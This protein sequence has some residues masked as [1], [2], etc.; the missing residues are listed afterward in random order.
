MS[1][2]RFSDRYP[3]RVTIAVVLL[4]LVTVA[5]VAS[6]FTAT[7]IMRGY[8]MDR[9]DTELAQAAP[10]L[11]DRPPEFDRPGGGRLPSAFVFQVSN[12]DGTKRDPPR[13]SP[14]RETDPQ[15]DLPVV[16]RAQVVQL[17]GKPFTADSGGTTWR[18]LALPQVEGDGS[19][20]VAQ[21]LAALDQTISQLVGVQIAVGAILLVL[22]G[23]VATYVVRRSLRG[24][25]G[26][27]NIRRWP[28]PVETRAGAYR[29]VTRA[30]RSAGCRW[31]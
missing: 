20:M 4:M 19:V 26:T 9:V 24:L 14:I 15:P 6:G 17:G 12:A 23:G 16:T 7:A 10:R 25:E 28:S 1:H 29:S 22:L 11:R 31:R 2:Q 13:S 8:L 3:L 21:S 30:P 5:L 18:V 27:S